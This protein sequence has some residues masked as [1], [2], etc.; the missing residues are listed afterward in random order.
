MCLWQ[1][2]GVCGQTAYFQL[3]R[4]TAKGSCCLRKKPGR[5]KRGFSNGS[6]S[7]KVI[8]SVI[9][10]VCPSFDL[11]ILAD[12]VLSCLT[13][14][15]TQP[16][17]SL[18]PFLSF[19]FLIYLLIMLLQLSHFPPHSSPSCPPPSLPHS[20]P[21]V[22]VHRKAPDFTAESPPLRN[23]L[24]SQVP[25]GGSGEGVYVRFYGTSW[26]ATPDLK[27]N[28]TAPTRVQGELCSR[29]FYL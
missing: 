9:C 6:F 2:K 27:C 22:H 21:I 3:S 24:G 23:Y 16:E 12:S 25:C 26:A 5:G 17:P 4:F 15:H 28:R 19:F 20:P 18:T 29:A 11:L 14:V 10:F 13:V 8:V 7:G 1:R